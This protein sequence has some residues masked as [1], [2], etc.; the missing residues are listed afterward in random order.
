MQDRKIRCGR[1]RDRKTRR[2][3]PAINN[4]MNDRMNSTK[5]A[6]INGG[7]SAEATVSRSSAKGVIAALRENYDSVTNIELDHD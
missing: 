4:R 7:H 3:R 5:I 6:V 2:R 1:I